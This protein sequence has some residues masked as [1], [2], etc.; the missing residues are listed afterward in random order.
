MDTAP[1]INDDGPTGPDRAASQVRLAV[2]AP[3]YEEAAGIG[4]FYEALKAVLTGLDGVTHEIILV[5]DGSRDATLEKLLALAE[6]D[7]C[8]K[9]YSL[10]R[11]FG[12]QVALTAG[13]DAA[14]GDAVVMMDSDLQHPPEL[15][16]RMLHLWR[17]G[18]D[19]V[20]AVREQTADST[21]FK[22]LTSSAFY[23]FINLLSSTPIVHG[24]SDFCLLSRRAHRAL[25]GLPE[26]HRFLR[27]MLSWV[28]F[29]RTFLPYQA[30][31]RVAG[32][33]KYTLYKMLGLAFDAAFSFSVTPIRL[34]MRLGV[35]A[36]LL[37]LCYLGYILFRFFIY[38][39]LVRGWPSVIFVVVF[40]G[41][42]QLIFIGLIGEYVGRVFE[43]VKR[44]PL[45]L[46][47]HRPGRTRALRRGASPEEIDKP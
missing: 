10:S 7:P 46:L 21:L 32:Q 6:R 14:R 15:I 38:Q 12:H 20:S 22:K 29:K 39:D 3:C 47:K 16:P 9:V 37:S 26:R 33:S 35:L 5:D 42:M 17:E 31:A 13:L 23:W 8:V 18:N 41:G 11:N 4:H 25:R 36:V 40:L 45:Y 44:R 30:A 27:G 19:I 28:G 1:Q 2:V 24:A 43:E 34:A